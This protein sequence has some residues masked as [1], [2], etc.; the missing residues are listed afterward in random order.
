[1]NKR[2]QA[3]YE[4]GKASNTGRIVGLACRLKEAQ[5]GGLSQT[6]TCTCQIYAC[7]MGVW[8]GRGWKM[9]QKLVKCEDSW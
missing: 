5:F 7:W 1:M 4:A 6:I 8:I 3:C 9:L 2:R